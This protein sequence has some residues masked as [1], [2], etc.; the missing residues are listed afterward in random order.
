MKND[1]ARRSGKISRKYW[2]FYLIAA[3]LIAGCVQGKPYSGTDYQA[4]ENTGSVMQAP[5]RD[6][7]AVVQTLGV[8]TPVEAVS[9]RLARHPNSISNLGD[10]KKLVQWQFTQ[11]RSLVHIA[12][13]FDQNGLVEIQHMSQ[14]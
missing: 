8:G 10:G 6:P 3:P 14:Y 12:I 2:G 5:P 11:K 1:K 7:I 4:P 9:N 13:L